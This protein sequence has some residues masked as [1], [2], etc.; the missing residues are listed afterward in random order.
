PIGGTGGGWPSEP[1]NYLGFRYDGELKSIHHVESY[2]VIE[3]FAPHFTRKS[4][5]T[6]RPH[7]LYSLGAAIKPTRR[8]PTNGNGDSIYPSG[9]KWVFIDLLLTAGSVAEAARVTKQRQAE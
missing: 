6:S 8:V 3:N 4:A 2:D 9:R 1:P 7:F 5:P